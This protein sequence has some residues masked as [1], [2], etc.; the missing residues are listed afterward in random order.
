MKK[1]AI[2]ILPALMSFVFA[3]T[4]CTG[5]NNG[6]EVEKDMA[7]TFR[8]AYAEILEMDA[9]D[10]TKD[11]YLEYADMVDSAVMM[12]SLLSSGAKKELASEKV[13]L[14]ALSEKIGEFRDEKIIFF[15][16]PNGNDSNPGTKAAPF[17][18]IGRAEQVVRPGGT[19]YIRGGTYM[20]QET[21]I[22]DRVN[23][24]A[25]VPAVYVFNCSQ[26]GS[27]TAPIKYIAYPGDP[28]PVFDLSNVQPAGARVYVFRV[29]G[30]NRQ[31]KGFDVIGTWVPELSTN[32]QSICFYNDGGSSNLYENLVMRDGAGIGFYLR[33]GSN[34]L[35]LN[36]DAYNNYAK[37]ASDNRNGNVD[38]FGMHP[39]STSAG[40]GNVFR[41]CR[42]WL[43]SDDGFDL[44]H[45]FSAVTIDNCWSFLNGYGDDPLG[46]TTG[47]ALPGGGNMQ[48]RN[49]G[50]GTGIKAGGYGMDGTG[51]FP[52]LSA[53]PRHTVQFCLSFFN[54][55]RGFY[56]NYHLGGI[57]WY[58]NTAYQDAHNFNMRNRQGTEVDGSGRGNEVDGYNHEMINNLSYAPRSGGRIIAQLNIERSTLLNNSFGFPMKQGSAWVLMPEIEITDADFISL[59]WTEMKK[60]RKADGSLPDINF[61]R[62]VPTSQLVDAGRVIP[63]FAYK[64]AR[65]NL[66]CFE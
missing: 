8:D 14:D 65:P 16:A 62:P 19:V 17:K 36:C 58:N 29:N 3:L 60:P 24:S 50:D 27:P 49:L 47:P 51:P 13:K 6:N 59:D 39:V 12:F 20:V 7:A 21:E 64:G 57:N 52:T 1:T 55:N 54:R 61:M 31:F 46:T 5:D 33:A 38:G 35:V 23:L 48:L 18:T 34:N 42:A 44:I 4:G 25:T 10:I 28:R 11:N 26:S 37:L 53:V 43:N 45:S 32:T 15:I 56:A 40:T 63:G 66:G 9:A 2:V 41:G 22:A 30:S